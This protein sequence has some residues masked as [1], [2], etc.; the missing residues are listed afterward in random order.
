M[1]ILGIDF[2]NARWNGN[3]SFS[4]PV[5]NRKVRKWT[6]LPAGRG[7][8]EMLRLAAL[9]CS[10]VRFVPR[11]VTAPTSLL[12][13]GSAPLRLE[14][15]HARHVPY[16]RHAGQTEVGAYGL[17][18]D[19]GGR[20]DILTAS[21]LCLVPGHLKK[22]QSFFGSGNTQ[23][24]T[25]AYGG[26]PRSHRGTDDFTF[27]D[28]FFRAGRL[29]S[30]FDHTARLTD[31]VAFLTRLHYRAIGRSR[32]P[33]IRTLESLCQL[34]AKGLRINTAP[35]RQKRCDF[36]SS[37][38]QLR[39]WQQDVARMV[40][41]ATRHILD[42]YPHHGQPLDAPGVVIMDRPDLCWADPAGAATWLSL[43]DHYLPSMQFIVTLG[44]PAR[45]RI[46]KSLERGRLSLP[47][48]GE[49]RPPCRL[50]HLPRGTT[51]LIDIDSR[52][53]NLAL[54]KLSRYL[55]SQGRHVELARGD[56]R[57]RTVDEVFASSVFFTAASQ[58][59][60]ERLRQRFGEAITFGGSGVDLQRRLP[61][62]IEALPPDYTLY[63]EL[64]DRALGFVTRGCPLRCAFCIVPEKEGAV[65][66]VSDLDA[67]LQ[68]SRT[69]LILLDD[70]LLAHPRA[71][72]LLDEM[73]ARDIAVNFT[74]TMDLRMVDAALAKLI[75]RIRCSNTRFTR[76]AYYFSLNR[77]RGLEQI[78]KRYDLFN[79]QRSDNVEFV[80]M[81]GFD[82]SLEE[83][84]ERLR[85]LKTLPGAYVF[86]QLYQPTIGAPPA[87]LDGF[88]NDRADELIDELVGIN[89][90]QNM[91]SMETYYRWIS[92]L[93]VLTFGK[94]HNRLV[95]VIFRYN[96]R[97]RKGQYIT[98]LAGTSPGV[99]SQAP[100]LPP[101]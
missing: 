82:T 21:E 55:K 35:W 63:P 97:D 93:Y 7:S 32:F 28:P 4:L 86:T 47:E 74:Q 23:F 26:R 1:Y 16:D 24:F 8:R 88:F 78:R 99:A 40:I 10:G 46:A 20:A 51:L 60:I 31:P 45:L 27:A 79:F 36:G 56:T 11:L 49:R 38:A 94:L 17:I 100:T 64:E 72:D 87:R 18:M 34:L 42:A 5:R 48:R 71:A 33:A 65:R 81:Y 2:E 92:R 69:K 52:L 22:C 67:L 73:A 14:S 37:W 12:A 57:V 101:P 62:A 59:K 61:A 30:L 91:K 29:R 84:L 3:G 76:S 25:L 66:V 89:F 50:R 53:P 15:V 68:G 77:A 41:D 98:S 13:N 85:F 83:D 39:P 19:A 70:N 6:I 95:D 54:M 9:A 90:G 58:S 80:F 75:R 44:E 43:L 96:R